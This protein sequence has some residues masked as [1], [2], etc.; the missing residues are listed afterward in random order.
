MS[1]DKENI[2]EIRTFTC[3]GRRSQSWDVLCIDLIG[4]YNIERKNKTKKPLPLWTLTMI[5]PT[6]GWF[7]I[8]EIKKKSADTVENI[9]LNRRG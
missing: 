4:P 6:T 2:S 5:D 1:D 7:E 8:R 3:E 9:P